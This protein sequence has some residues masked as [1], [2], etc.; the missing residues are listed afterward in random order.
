MNIIA[1]LTE[2]KKIVRVLTKRVIATPLQ[3]LPLPFLV[4]LIVD[5]HSLVPN[6]YT[7]AWEINEIDAEEMVKELE[8]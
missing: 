2:L 5:V 3:P 7:Q 8:P 6:F 4:S 1:A